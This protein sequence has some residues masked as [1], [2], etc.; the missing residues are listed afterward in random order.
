VAPGRGTGAIAAEP[1]AVPPPAVVIVDR[2]LPFDAERIALTRAYLRDHAGLDQP[3]ITITPHVIVLHW[4]DSATADSAW[5]TFAPTR[6]PASRAELGGGVQV[7][8]SSQFLVDRDGTIY[9]L[10]PENWMARHTIGLNHV[11][12]GVENVGG[13]AAGDLT[14]AQVDADAALVRDLAAR[15]PITH[16]IGHLE[17]RAFEGHPYFREADPKYRTGKTDPG[18]AFMAA[19]RVKVADLGLQGPP[20]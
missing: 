10:M 1:S 17:Y 7:N 4:T 2:P 12:I 11:A 18:V 20:R 19:V 16:L 8:V 5:A 6:L 3:D 15:F 13:G 9:R 14:P